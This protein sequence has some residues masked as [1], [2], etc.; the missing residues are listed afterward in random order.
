MIKQIQST[1]AAL[2]TSSYSP[3]YI[4]NNG[5]SAGQ[6]RYNT[7]TQNMDVYDGSMW[8]SVSQQVSIGLNHSAE[9]SLRWA[10]AKMAEEIELKKLSKE[11]P[12]IKIAYENLNKAQEQL[13][14]TIILSKE[15][16]QYETAS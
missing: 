10:Q 3:P 5:Q 7:G 6:V 11:H 2:I 15:H 1:S 14:A 9:E 16:E 8:I 12:A 13:K 4:N